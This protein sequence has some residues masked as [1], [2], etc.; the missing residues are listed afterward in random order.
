M[1]TL[2][3]ADSPSLSD[4]TNVTSITPVQRCPSCQGTDHRRNTYKKCPKYKARR[5]SEQIIG[6]NLNESLTTLSPADSPSLSDFTV[7]TPITPVQRCPSC[8]GTD[9]RRN[10]NLKCPEYQARRTFEPIIGANLN[11]TFDFA[12]AEDME[13]NPLITKVIITMLCFIK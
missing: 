13:S 5:G 3:T 1:T 8:Q 2:S 9:H 6:A 12:L 7:V 10:T 11:E 4:F